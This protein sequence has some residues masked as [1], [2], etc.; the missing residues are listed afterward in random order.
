LTYKAVFVEKAAKLIKKL[1]YS[2]LKTNKMKKLLLSSIIMFGVCTFA[3]AQADKLAADKQVKAQT[4]ARSN[5]L[6]TSTGATKGQ[7][8]DAADIAEKQAVKN[9]AA[10]DVASPNHVI[11]ATDQ[12][13][14]KLQTEAK[15]AASKAKQATD[16]QAKKTNDN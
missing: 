6:T 12:S 8:S 10:S 13:K 3:T 9:A 4:A 11:S 2:L 1:F 5:S 16:A 7:T 15:Q 14:S